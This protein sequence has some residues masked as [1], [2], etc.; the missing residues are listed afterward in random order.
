MNTAQQ[1][2]TT[3]ASTVHQEWWFFDGEQLGSLGEFSTMAEAASQAPANSLGI[4]S[5]QA[6]MA[7]RTQADL[8]GALQKI[9]VPVVVAP[10]GVTQSDGDYLYVTRSGYPGE[11]HI[12]AE[13][14]GFVV[15]AW[16]HGDEGECVATMSVMSSD[17]E[18]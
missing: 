8:A 15:D 9:G 3:S 11:L 18:P 2:D 17:M 6:L 10:W 13:G 1:A 12:K 16:R 5:K 7:T 4:I 14:E